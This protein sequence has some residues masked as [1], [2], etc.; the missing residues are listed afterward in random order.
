MRVD[1][2]NGDHTKYLGQGTYEADT[3]VYFWVNP[4]GSLGSLHDAT[5]KPDED[6]IPPG[7]ELCKS[8]KDNPMILMDNGGIVYGCQVWWSPTEDKNASTIKTAKSLD[9]A[10]LMKLAEESVEKLF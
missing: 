1:V 7:A 6:Q 4:D 8:E 5:E 2:W 9:L 3:V 10:E